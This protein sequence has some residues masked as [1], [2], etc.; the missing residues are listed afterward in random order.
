[1]RY[2]INRLHPLPKK[3]TVKINNKKYTTNKNKLIFKLIIFGINKETFDLII[4]LITATSSN[5]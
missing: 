2:L 5:Q 3:F 4:M 1:M